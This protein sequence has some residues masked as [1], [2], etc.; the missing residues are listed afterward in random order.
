[1]INLNPIHLEWV[2][3]SLYLR[4][5]FCSESKDVEANRVHDTISSFVRKLHVLKN[6]KKEKSGI[7]TS[8]ILKTNIFW[9]HP[10]DKQLCKV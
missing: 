7:S 2:P 9:G 8:P 3:F 10:V 5:G 6:S 4:L 1:M